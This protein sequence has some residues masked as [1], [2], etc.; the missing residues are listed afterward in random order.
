M[1]S[2]IWLWFGRNTKQLTVLFALMAGVYGALQWAS[3]NYVARVKNASEAVDRLRQSVDYI[4]AREL[5]GFW[6]S[7]EITKERQAI[8]GTTKTGD[9]FRKFVEQKV[10]SAHKNTLIRAIHGYNSV[11]VC[12]IQGSCDSITLCMH[13]AGQIQDLRCNFRESIN[14]ISENGNICAIQEMNEFIDNKCRDWLKTYLNVDQYDGIKDNYCLYDKGTSRSK[15]SKVC[16]N[17]M[18]GRYSKP[19]ISYFQ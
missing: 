9:D 13:L 18:L 16:D 14:E 10:A 6:L 4:A 11:S 15:L 2:S 7:D 8:N 19:W 12:A 3:T 5:E 17:P 1:G